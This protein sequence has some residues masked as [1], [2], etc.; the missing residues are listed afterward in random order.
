MAKN[1]IL[2]NA[3]RGKVEEG[4]ENIALD[5]LRSM[6][7]VMLSRIMEAE[8]SARVAPDRYERSDDR[9]GYRNGTRARRF[10]T[11]LG[12]IDLRVPKLRSGDYVPA[13]L[14]ERSRSERALASVV[15]QAVHGGVASC[16]VEKIFAELG[17]D[18]RRHLE[19]ASQRDVPRT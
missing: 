17:I 10:D 16:R 13:F 19:V 1:T 9:S 6:L 12:T 11:R 14:E 4:S 15:R 2:G 7:E 8:V 5:D 18:P 3:L